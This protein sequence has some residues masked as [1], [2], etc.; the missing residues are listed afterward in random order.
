ME[1]T[2]GAPP[3][4]E[5]A[6][7]LVSSSS[8]GSGEVFEVK[9]SVSRLSCLT[10]VFLP[11]LWIY[12]ACMGSY[13][14]TLA[15][16]LFVFLYAVG[17]NTV[18]KMSL[19]V[20]NLPVFPI[21]F[22][23]IWS[24]TYFIAEC[25][26]YYMPRSKRPEF[27]KALQCFDFFDSDT[28][29]MFKTPFVILQ[30]ITIFVDIVYIASRATFGLTWYA[31]S[32][33]VVLRHLMI[34]IRPLFLFTLSV[35]TAAVNTVYTTFIPVIFALTILSFCLMSCNLPKFVSHIYWTLYV[36]GD[37]AFVAYKDNSFKSPSIYFWVPRWA[38]ISA[39]SVNLLLIGAIIGANRHTAAFPI[40]LLKNV[41]VPWWFLD[42]IPYVVICTCGLFCV[43]EDSWQ[44]YG[45][46]AFA[47]FSS[48][49][50]VNILQRSSRFVLSLMALVYC[51]QTLYFFIKKKE[52]Y[53]PKY[54]FFICLLQAL[55]AVFVHC[56]ASKKRPGEDEPTITLDHKKPF[57]HKL[58][59]WIIF[60]IFAFN[61]GLNAVFSSKF[62]YLTYDIPL[63][64]I[65]LLMIFTFFNRLSWTLLNLI[66]FA[67]TSIYFIAPLLEKKLDIPWL[68]DTE[69]T[70]DPHVMW[71]KVW[72]FII[73]FLLT[74]IQRYYY[75]PPPQLVIKFSKSVGVFAALCLSCIYI[76]NSIFTVLY[77]LLIVANLFLYK[78]N[79]ALIIINTILTSSQIVVL[80]AFGYPEL[81]NKIG[82]KDF[83]YPFFGLKENP[84][85]IKDQM[86]PIMILIYYTF[87]GSI[88][89][90]YKAD[91]NH[92][93]NKYAMLII[94]N[95][96][97]LIIK[98]SFY[99]FWSA[100]F[101]V[102]AI[103]KGVSVVGAVM[104]IVLGI[105]KVSGCQ[106]KGIGIAL[107]TIFILDVLFVIVVAI[108]STPKKIQKIVDIIGPMTDTSLSKFANVLV[109]LC[110]YINMSTF[111]TEPIHPI[112]HEVGQ[113][114]ASLLL[115]V[116]EFTLTIMAVQEN[117]ILNIFGIALVLVI[118]LHP[119][120][121]ICGA[122]AITIILTI[123]LGYA[124][125]LLI[126][127]VHKQ[128]QW[129]DYFLVTNVK[130]IEVFY[131]FL[132]MIAFCLFVE[133]GTLNI[134]V[135][136]SFLTAYLPS[137]LSVAAA[138][139]SLYGKKYLLMV[140]SIM[141]LVNLMFTFHTE[142][143]HERSFSVVTWFAFAI[144]A[145][146]A[147]RPIR[148]IP[149]K[150]SVFDS[151]LG[152]MTDFDDD[153]IFW[154]V[155]FWLEFLLR[156]CLNS[157]L[158]NEVHGRE[159]KRAECRKKRAQIIEE[160]F[161]IDHRYSD[162]NFKHTLE[163]L[164]SSITNLDI[165]DAMMPNTSSIELIKPKEAPKEEK[166]NKNENG[167][168]D[169]RPPMSATKQFYISILKFIIN[170]LWRCLI[171]L[172]NKLIILASNFTDINLEPGV[173]VQFLVNM[174][175]MMSEM[176]D[177]FVA[178]NALSIPEAYQGFAKQIPMSYLYHFQIFHK[179]NIKE[180]TD[181]NRFPLFYHYVK[182]CSRQAI[183][184]LLLAMSFYYPVEERSIFALAFF[185]LALV[186]V[187]FNIETY[188]PFVYLS[189]LYMFM[190]ELYRSYK[191][192]D[193]IDSFVISLDEQHRK[194]R[195][196][197]CFGLDLNSGEKLYLLLVFIL[198]CAS[199]TYSFT[200][201]FQSRRPNQHKPVDPD[202]AQPKLT[203]SE[204]LLRRI[205]MK[206]FIQY[207][208]NKVV[209]LVDVI[210][211]CIALFF[212]LGWTVSSSSDSLFSG[213]ATITYDFVFF[214]M[215][216]FIFI[217]FNQWVI[218][219]RHKLWLFT[220]NFLY[221]IFTFIYMTY[222]I[223][224]FTSDGCFEHST[225][226]LFY[227]L[228][229]LSE[230]ILACNCMFGFARMPPSLGNPNALFTYIKLLTIANVPFLF[231]FIQ[232]TKWL[233]CTTSLN[234]F[235]FMIIGQLRSKL[236]KQVALL[237]LFPATS[238]KKSHILGL[239][240]IFFL[241][242]LLF[243]PFIIMMS[244][245]STSIP[246]GVKV[247]TV[248]IGVYGLPE[249]FT[250]TVLPGD[251]TILTTSMQKD[252]VKAGDKTLDAFYSNSRKE[253]QYFIYP[254]ITMTN[255]IISESSAQYAMYTI[256]N[257]TNPIFI[258]YVTFKFTVNTP[259]TKKNTDQLTFTKTGDQLPKD[260]L[261][262]LYQALN[263][264]LTL[265]SPQEEISF[266][267]SNFIPLYFLIPLDKDAKFIKGYS[268]N[269]TFTFVKSS[270]GNS[271]YWNVNT[272]PTDKMPSGVQAGP[273]GSIVF[274]KP[275]YDAVIGTLLSKT[276]GGFYGLYLFVIF[277]CGKFV[278]GFINSF[279]TDLWIDKMGK[280]E[281][282]LNVILAIEAH[283]KAGD[284]VSEF[285]T[286]MML[287]NTIRSVHNIVKIGGYIPIDEE[288]KKK[289]TLV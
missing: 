43:L 175:N 52:G 255:W 275:T 110:A 246:N 8:S 213:A 38:V 107:Y 27:T 286:A 223:P 70:T 149:Q 28:R 245:S 253:S 9:F 83:F 194:L 24:L 33:I 36:L 225:Y 222:L 168:I 25:T 96:W 193:L 41:Q 288:Q 95:V 115:S 187:S 122:R 57:E 61:V 283:R 26:M 174:R 40:R 68:Y 1:E 188:L 224:V 81:T 177:G 123:I 4:R 16:M 166:D 59:Q 10:E 289:P 94:N 144:L 258:P 128:N 226:W 219:S 97:A 12:S 252:I 22:S 204:K 265:E 139:I 104:L 101:L 20:Y 244:S 5:Q 103:S 90:K 251:D 280:P 270:S 77:Q 229:I 132:T 98:F 99:F 88:A 46:L 169:D 236:S 84:D 277:T 119:R 206:S 86:I 129:L 35:M 181:K 209:L 31:Q 278:R 65:L 72:P 80:A 47:C 48:L 145:I 42:I 74:A 218:L 173:H 191:L 190:R 211:F 146:K 100:I 58:L 208:F 162:Y 257:T 109:C 243:I 214:L 151:A 178:N 71:S 227:F 263:C 142:T 254:H 54:N 284:L 233:A 34:L 113:C 157:P 39:T 137:I 160:M 260:I 210:A 49:F 91:E 125:A 150:E 267:I 147:V 269:T 247:A 55:A 154:C 6:A 51:G 239:G 13:G 18:H 192:G 29:I 143:F 203:F 231:E 215:G 216:N 133:F 220:F 237:K 17:I 279:F 268:F 202:L 116:V 124:L 2:E 117:N 232:L 170:F 19:K 179:L 50:G 87:F 141:L 198:A 276:G 73:L 148:I 180:I 282:F 62:D 234:M 3:A 240:F 171:W 56:T 136:R 138:V 112:L 248:S 156:C 212:Y 127:P 23:L 15:H 228:R 262:K 281:I 44:S 287:I 249:F 21:V 241:F 69:V 118:L 78:W 217:M 261:E 172:V 164:K 85:V 60:I 32:K 167:E 53:H 273:I 126:Y 163:V 76:E 63:V 64:T 250:G 165:T 155:C 93:V 102:V 272:T 197:T 159:L 201:P 196:S 161:E 152:I 131:I 183:P 207:S 271:F 264:T 120:V 30:M 230:I 205:N 106:T 82:K 242:A 114:L 11:C 259:T 92:R 45:V 238:K 134:N 37:F 256:A 274:S 130:T 186:T 182:L 75:R 200:H 135:G 66:T 285:N 121:S 185:F 184:M 221:A 105:L 7:S 140:H 14:N 111:N 79:Y 189:G 67:S 266:N 108:V 235:D 153:N 195:V 176:V 158:Y 89:R 199:Q